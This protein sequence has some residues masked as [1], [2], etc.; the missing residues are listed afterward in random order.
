MQGRRRIL[1]T[2]T[3]IAGIGQFMTG[4]CPFFVPINGKL[5]A[6]RVRRGGQAAERKKVVKALRGLLGHRLK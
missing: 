1:K 4:S 5:A 2:D 3:D 6:G